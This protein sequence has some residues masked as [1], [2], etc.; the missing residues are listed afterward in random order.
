[1]ATKTTPTIGLNILPLS[2]MRHGAPGFDYH[3]ALDLEENLSASYVAIDTQFSAMSSYET[4]ESGT[5]MQLGLT[6]LAV[7][8]SLTGTQGDLTD[9]SGSFASYVNTHSVT[10]PQGVTGVTGPG[11]PQGATGI[12]GVT[13]LQGVPGVTGV[14]GPMNYTPGTTGS[15]TGGSPTSFANAL[16]RIAAAITAGVATG[17]IA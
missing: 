3:V 7:S 15:W 1:M 12:N 17:P 11:G 6:L 9:L 4:V 13:G 8:G 5:I 16:D 2:E 14:T 10:G